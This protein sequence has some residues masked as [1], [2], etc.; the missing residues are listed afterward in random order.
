MRRELWENKL[1]ELG[2]KQLEKK[3][4][5]NSLS[6]EET[7]V[8]GKASEA[9]MLVSELHDKEEFLK[10]EIDNLEKELCNIQNAFNKS[11]EK[12]LDL[13]SQTERSF[14]LCISCLNELNKKISNEEDILSEIREAE[15]SAHQRI[16]KEE[17]ILSEKV[18]DYNI[19]KERLEKKYKELFPDTKLIL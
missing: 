7:V 1:K 14:D 19:Y 2:G 17:K 11:I 8:R 4:V 5:I 16:V 6:Q 9:A 10:G 15:N 18:R 12:D 13:L 3:L